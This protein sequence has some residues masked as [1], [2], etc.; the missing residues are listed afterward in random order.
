M[1]DSFDFNVSQRTKYESQTGLFSSPP[2]DYA[3]KDPTRERELW[4]RK[5]DVRGD[6]EKELQVGMFARAD[7]VSLRLTDTH[8]PLFLFV[9][10]LEEREY[11]LFRAEQQLR[12]EFGQFAAKLAQLLDLAADR[13][14]KSEGTVTFSIR[15]CRREQ[16]RL[17]FRVSESNDFK[18]LDHISLLLS[19]AN[20]ERLKKHLAARVRETRTELASAQ[21]LAETLRLR[22][23]SALNDKCELQHTMKQLEEERQAVEEKR[24]REFNAR[25]EEER[26]SGLAQRAGL[27]A[28]LSESERLVAEL[29]SLVTAK[30]KDCEDEATAALGREKEL[31]AKIRLLEGEL[32]T[33][34]QEADQA[35]RILR[36]AELQLAQAETDVQVAKQSASRVQ[37]SLDRAETQVREALAGR[38]E[39]RE[40]ALR[41]EN[42][43]KDKTRLCEKLEAKLKVSS[44]EIH[45]ANEIMES[46]EADLQRKSSKAKESKITISRLEKENSDL[47][48]QSGSMA[49]QIT[50]MA[51]TIETL[52]GR[53]TAALTKQA[54]LEGRVSELQK[55][56]EASQSSVGFLSQKVSEQSRPFMTDVS[57]GQQHPWVSSTTGLSASTQALLRRTT[58]HPP[59]DSLYTT[60]VVGKPEAAKGVLPA[61]SWERGKTEYNPPAS[62][63]NVCAAPSKLSTVPFHPLDEEEPR[64]P[65]SKAISPVKFRGK[66]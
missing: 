46:F 23:D 31:K 60:S 32:H 2:A 25:L 34:L 62:R 26:S 53:E 9:W 49:K 37:L 14:D 43:L 12:V 58:H 33:A 52:T 56:L 21:S 51:A 22:L 10:D 40:G 47:R 61:D 65:I 18:E 20:D 15:I 13:R 30:A 19:A 48:S 54:E 44:A 29:R 11:A 3:E 63:L 35:R 50:E 28:R 41:A 16:S 57:L 39:A 38:D 4:A 55:A 27:D 24:R 6:I 36:N 45:K 66:L 42:E 8:D 5:V 17:L 7:E 64:N 1:K 59:T